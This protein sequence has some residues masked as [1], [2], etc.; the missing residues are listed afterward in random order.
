M[1]F[2]KEHLD[3]SKF[4]TISV[5]D[6]NKGFQ[7]NKNSLES[8]I[9]NKSFEELS[10]FKKSPFGQYW[11]KKL[12][13]WALKTYGLAGVFN[14]T[15]FTIIDASK[16]IGDALSSFYNSLVDESWKD[17]KFFVFA[18]PD[19]TQVLKD[20]AD[21]AN[22]PKENEVYFFIETND[23]KFN[24]GKIVR[25]K[26]GKMSIEKLRFQFPYLNQTNEEEL[27]EEFLKRPFEI[28]YGKSFDFFNNAKDEVE[29][30]P[31]E[32][33]DLLIK[34]I[35]YDYQQKK[36]DDMSWSIMF[37]Q[38]TEYLGISIPKMLMLRSHEM[39]A[40][41]YNEEKYWNA[42]LSKDF[43]P[44]FLPNFLVPE[45]RKELKESILK[46]FQKKI[47]EATVL[48][49]SDGLLERIYKEILKN[50]LLYLFGKLSSVLE[51]GLKILDDILP[52]GE[53]LNELYNLNA[54]L[55]G[56]WNGCIEFAAGIVDLVALLL[57]IERDGL[58]YTLS[59]A[60]ME[61]MEEFFNEV[62]FG[63]D[64]FVKKL[65]E[66]FKLA[67]KDYQLWYL[68]YG[69]NSFYWYKKLGELTP[70]ILSIVI[71]AL[72]AGKAAK[73]AEV[74]KLGSVA[75]KE[76][77]KEVSEEVLQKSAKELSEKLEQ[78]TAKKEVKE[79][80]ENA[81]KEIDSKIYEEQPSETSKKKGKNN[82][83]E[84]DNAGLLKTVEKSYQGLKYKILIYSDRISWRVFNE[85][86]LWDNHVRLWGGELEF[87]FNTYGIKGLGQQ[88][89]EET[90]EIFGDKIKTVKVE[91]KQ[92]P[93][94]PDGES[95]GYKQFNKKFDET[96]DMHEAVKSTTFYKT[97]SKHE[98]HK[99]KDV[100]VTRDNS[101]IT[102]LTK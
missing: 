42:T 52:E 63:F 51:E 75:S 101:I 67:I 77:A 56:L 31:K 79:A 1:D 102:I 76:T 16:K 19:G 10:Q 60:L 90:F 78:S 13:S 68:K 37:L 46:N 92:L 18:H 71:P 64:N 30:T 98:F 32:L 24:F 25:V 85:K 91:W 36:F 66:K 93:E 72:K 33:K 57:V 50:V 28:K 21:S 12:P 41:K 87:D 8:V 44:S 54:F 43:T 23:G 45:K 20:Y 61:K 40:K 47:D 99:I 69:D 100:Y 82:F 22:S 86:F 3:L 29:N 84:Y 27:A 4:K 89:T 7:G 62:A 88:W 59:D 83:D 70:D 95:L 5:E 9:G 80:F 39:R 2:F 97:M 17:I 58:G 74:S 48:D 6:L 15:N 73:I 11:E 81:E 35:K 34:A 26:L 55:V 96:Y 38:G 49:M 14:K 53:T 94:Y 65:W